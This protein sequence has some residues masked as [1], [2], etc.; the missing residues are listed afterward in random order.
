MPGLPV[1]MNKRF[2]VLTHNTRTLI[3]RLKEFVR[4]C[5]RRKS[6][7][8]AKDYRPSFPTEMITEGAVKV[9]VPKL[10][11]FVKEPSEYAPSKA[12][13]FYNPVME[14]NRDITVLIVQAHQ[15]SLGRD[16]DVFEPLAGCGIRGVRLATEVRGVK[17]VTLGDINENAYRLAAHN[18]Q[19]NNL[20]KIVVV[21]KKEANYLLS[22][23]SAPRK[24]FDV[25]DIDPF[26]SPV[27]FLDSAVR[28]LR[29]EGLIALTATD[30]ASLSG[31]H[32]K[33][34]IRKYGGKPLRTEYCHE[35]AVRLL[36]GCL[37]SVA[38]KH[39]LGVNI[40]FSH[41]GEHYVRV[42]ATIH[43]G[44]RS[45]DEN[46][47]KMGFIL[48]CFKCFH[49]EVV[50]GP[51]WIEQ[52]QACSE[53]GSTLSAAGPLWI[54]SIS[55]PETCKAMEQELRTRRLRLAVK[56]KKMLDLIADESIGS[57]TYFVID[58]MCDALNLQV[59]SSR[60]VIEALKIEGFHVTPTHFST[61]GVRTDAPASVLAKVLCRLAAEK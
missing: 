23:H 47:K 3:F 36:A 43:Y 13:V 42:Y 19:I 34:C 38:G 37:A 25:V 53:C 30:M 6:R 61:R 5:D 54:G 44:A 41:R 28:A 55:N 10:S 16:I 49:R 1:T 9:L 26:G 15:K 40:V 56:T 33:A 59:P 20:N 21:K 29:N 48:H 35:L 57:A 8:T 27:P 7:M 14:I 24:R 22:S 39:D 51:L 60:K 17:A 32:P 46:Q 45:A 11:A 50:R 12:P 58:N 4:D 18:V 2:L 52:K 31:V